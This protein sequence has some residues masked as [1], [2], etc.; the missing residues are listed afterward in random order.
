VIS[1]KEL[2]DR[3]KLSPTDDD[4]LSIIRANVI[5]LWEVRTNRLWNYRAG[6]VQ[7][8]MLDE[9]WQRF[10]PAWLS[11]TPVDETGTVT[12][13]DWDDGDDPE[14]LDEDEFTLLASSGKLVKLP[15][16]TPWLMNVRVTYS[17]GFDE[18][19]C[20]EDVREALAIQCQYA[21]LRHRGEKSILSGIT[22]PAGGVSFMVSADV[23]PHFKAQAALH[24]RHR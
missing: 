12:V 22:G 11:L 5:G 6:H 1:L 4:Q 13:E 14:A 8:F 18:S 7:T 23:H 19:S 20:P 9:S 2:R 21:L 15:R 10:A 17:G 24:R 16:V 3:L